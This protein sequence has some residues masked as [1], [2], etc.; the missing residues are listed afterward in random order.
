MGGKSGCKDKASKCLL[1]RWFNP[2]TYSELV[3]NMIICLTSYLIPDRGK[4]AGYA[5][6]ILFDWNPLKQIIL[7]AF[8]HILTLVCLPNVV[9]FY[10]CA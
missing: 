2:I 9:S 8:G 7:Q 3:S 4:E 5:R 6:N 10:Y 1:A